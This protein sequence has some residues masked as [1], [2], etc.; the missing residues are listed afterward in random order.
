MS[1]V[2]SLLWFLFNSADQ[3]I[4]QIVDGS[5]NKGVVQVSAIT[6][7]ILATSTLRGIYLV[8]LAPRIH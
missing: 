6:G 5:E 7:A 1:G 3:R 2:A 4:R 8:Y